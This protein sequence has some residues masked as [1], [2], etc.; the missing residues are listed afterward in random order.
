MNNET[1]KKFWQTFS[2]WKWILSLAFFTGVNVAALRMHVTDTTI[3]MDYT[4][5]AQ[6]DHIQK[7]GFTFS[8]EQKEDVMMRLV[9]V[10]KELESLKLQLR[11]W[12]DEGR[13]QT[14]DEK[15]SLM[16]N[17]MREMLLENGYKIEK[18]K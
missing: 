14:P 2:F 8:Q 17:A 16:K 15:I 13:L 9:L 3:H 10:E 11:D 4:E 18:N 5:K 6:I 1:I 7:Y 12:K